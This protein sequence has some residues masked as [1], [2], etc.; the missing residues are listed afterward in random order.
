ML[1]EIIAYTLMMAGL[2]LTM[3]ILTNEYLYGQQKQE[4]KEPIVNCKEVMDNDELCDIE[5]NVTNQS[6]SKSNDTHYLK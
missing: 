4:L 3:A 1:G 2:V 5:G 6:E